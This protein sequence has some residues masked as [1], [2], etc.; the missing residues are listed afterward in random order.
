[1]RAVSKFVN[2]LE[3]KVPPVAL[4][5]ILA[6]ATWL[7]SVYVP[8]LAFAT[9]WRAA[10]A[11]AFVGVGIVISLVGVVAFRQ[12]NTTVN[13]TKPGTTSAMVTSG[14]YRLSRNPMYVGFFFVL[15]GWALFLSHALA[16]AILPVFVMY[17]NRFQILPEE[18]ALSAKFGRE[19]TDYRHS[20]RRWV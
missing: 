4:V 12:A 7:L 8:S 2:A 18:R 13:P 1:M 6:L 5:L 11:V 16:F 14:V 17:M 20:V 19:F 9:P 3:L 10:V 15:I